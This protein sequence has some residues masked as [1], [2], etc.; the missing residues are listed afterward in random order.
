[1]QLHL[2]NEFTSCKPVQ[3]MVTHTELSIK[4]SSLNMVLPGAWRQLQVDQR[5]EG[6]PQKAGCF[7]SNLK[8][9]FWNLLLSNV[10]AKAKETSSLRRKWLLVNFRAQAQEHTAEP[11]T[12]HRNA[13][14]QSTKRAGAQV[15]ST[16]IGSARDFCVRLNGF[17]S[18]TDS[19]IA[20]PRTC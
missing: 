18:P 7:V 9:I 10:D 12:T 20:K 14:K 15:D 5:P 11:S 4:S 8:K 19:R 16:L 3:N 13:T 1:M 17:I 2:Q 6:V